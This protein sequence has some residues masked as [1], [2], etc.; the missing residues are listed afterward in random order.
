LIVP[1]IVPDD[2]PVGRFSVRNDGIR[3]TDD[4]Q[5][6]MITAHLTVFEGGREIDKLYPAK[7]FFRKHEEEPTTEVAIRRSVSE[8]LYVVMPAF[9]LK[10][11]TAS[12]QVVINPLVNWIWV[13]FGVMAL[14]TGIAL[15]PERTF[16]FA[17]ARLP[18][19][20][21]AAAVLLL[22]TGLLMVAGLLVLLTTQSL[23]YFWPSPLWE[24]HLKDGTRMQETVE[25]PR[26]SEQAFPGL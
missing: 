23:G 20:A 13:G 25:A 5:K 2:V 6:Q 7:W 8:D 16:N 24:V 11:Q 3:M 12:L 10:D 22:T 14:G 21:E 15:L 18:A 1:S 17:L 26:G 4:G 19:T 9:D